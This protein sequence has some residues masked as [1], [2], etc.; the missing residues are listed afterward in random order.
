MLLEIYEIITTFVLCHPV[1]SIYLMGSVIAI[2]IVYSLISGGHL[3]PDKKWKMFVV[4]AISSWVVLIAFLY[5]FLRGFLEVLFK[6]N[7]G[8]Q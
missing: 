5:G 6:N 2:G 7:E 3:I 4:S 8:G 1:L